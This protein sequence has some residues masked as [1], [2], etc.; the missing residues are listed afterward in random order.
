MPSA[1]IL[2]DGSRCIVRG[3]ITYDT[4]MPLK[5]QGEAILLESASQELQFDLSQVNYADSAALAL[6][7]AWLRCAKG[8]KKTLH[9]VHLPAAMLQLSRL[10]GVKTL[11]PVKE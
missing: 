10:C 2:C 6:L 5:Q 8:A 11:L 4:V 9:Y 3:V 1:E 7:F